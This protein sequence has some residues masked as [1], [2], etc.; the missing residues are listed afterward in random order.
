[1]VEATRG[2]DP[3]DPPGSYG[4]DGTMRRSSS[5]KYHHGH[6]RHPNHTGN[7]RGTYYHH[8][9]YNSTSLH[10]DIQHIKNVI[11]RYLRPI[12]SSPINVVFALLWAWALHSWYARFV[13]GGAAYYHQTEVEATTGVI[14]Y[15]LYDDSYRWSGGGGAFGGGLGDDYVGEYDEYGNN[16]DGS[17]SR[18]LD[19]VI[20]NAEL[21][22]R[23][24]PGWKMRIYHDGTVPPAVLESL[25]DRSGVELIDVTR[26]SSSSGGRS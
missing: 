4:D 13:Y 2:S 26:S 6:P 21:L 25:R 16:N 10:G 9:D 5:S 14:A 11:R 17:S 7:H 1:M 24:F 22:P 23:I 19:G 20:A 12:L 3:S 8:D 18:Y 15:S